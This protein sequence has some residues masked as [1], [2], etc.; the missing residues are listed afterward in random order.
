[1][2]IIIVGCGKVGLSI[3][4]S[5]VAEGHDVTV[6]DSRAASIAEI[7]NIYDAMGV[8]GS[9]VDPETLQEAGVAKAQMFIAATGSDEMNML[10]CFLAKRLG[11]EHTIARIRNPEYNDK[12]SVFLRQQLQLDLAVNPDLLAAN[13]LYNVLQLP[14]AAKLETFSRRRLEMVELRLKAESP[15]CGTPLYELRKKISGSFLVGVVQRGKDAFIPDGS[16]VLQAG[17]RIGLIAPPQDLQK[18]LNMLDPAKKEAHKVMLLGASRVAY[19]LTRRL[20]SAGCTVTVIE[21]DAD[22]C[23]DFAERLPKA[24]VICGDGARQELLMEEGLGNADA[25]VALTGNDS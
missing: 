22:R 1:M 8:C 21:K 10:S 4:S 18:L 24:M 17:D 20:L 19:Y 5:L 23:A 11:A 25:F 14:S 2:N 13:E 3:L 16:F 12:T 9:G 7:T 15:L 6:I